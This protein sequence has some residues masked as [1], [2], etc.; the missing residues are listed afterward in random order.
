MYKYEPKFEQF[1]K[2][3]IRAAKELQYPKEVIERLKM[4]NSEEEIC[5]IMV[6]A[7]HKKE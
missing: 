2:K 7:R 3:Q 5:R 6:T 1:R 4:S